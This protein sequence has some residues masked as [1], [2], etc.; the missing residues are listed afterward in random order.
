MS[1]RLRISTAAGLAVAVAVIGVAAA[2]YFAVRAELRGQVDDALN[3]RGAQFSGVTKAPPPRSG[4]PGFGQGGRLQGH[5]LPAPPPPLFG[6]REGSIQV[7]LP[8]GAVVHPPDNPLRLPVDKRARDLARRG[9][10]RY[11]TDV[12]V[13]NTHLRVL[14]VGVTPRGALQ[15]ARP[16]AEVDRAL[17]RV[18]LILIFAVGGGIALAAALGAGVAKA[19]LAPIA[20]FTSRTEAISSDLDLSQRLEVHGDDELARLAQSFNATLEALERSVDAQR[21][22]VA[23]ASHELRTPLASLRANIQILEE[24]RSL[25]PAD[26]ESL[27]DDIVEELDELT[28]LVGD[29]VELARGAK[30]GAA[31]DDV[32]LDEVVRALAERT[33]RRAGGELE[34][35]LRLEPTVVT[36]E[37]D[38]ISRAVSNL[39]DN[40]R[41]W[42]PHGG[43]VEVD[44]AGGLLTVR[45]HGPGFRDEDLPHVF[46]R[47][48]RAKAAR[49]MSGSGLGLAIVRQSAEAHGGSV[50]AAN[51]P[52]GGAVLRVRFG[53]AARLEEAGGEPAVGA[54]SR[55]C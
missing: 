40:A 49:G 45:D 11:L 2:V 48:Y 55:R 22:L 19:A 8:T 32:R 20:R 51:A 53:A 29:V 13:G 7:V 27:R 12:H 3:T 24:A 9:S 33:R 44:L 25:P 28:A 50:E 35:R 15:V 10:G 42:S 31:P 36:G 43:A 18:L 39:L 26:R 17:H 52:D 47:F 14:T 6:G 30:P 23:D 4:E 54:L 16:L 38:R 41:K 37:P 46:E 1:L 5:E 21:H 34:I